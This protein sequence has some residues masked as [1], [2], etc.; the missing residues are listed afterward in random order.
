[1]QAFQIAG[2]AVE[3][4]FPQAFLDPVPGGS[5]PVLAPFQIKGRTSRLEEIVEGH[6]G[7]AARSRPM[8]IMMSSLREQPVRSRIIPVFRVP[9]AA[10]DA[11]E[12][13]RP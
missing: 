1:L 8:K 13:E 10:A 2:K 11:A 7:H 4:E 3:A 12:G 5:P 9:P 6:P